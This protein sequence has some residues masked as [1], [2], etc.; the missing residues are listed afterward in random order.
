MIDRRQCRLSIVRQCALLGLAR[1]SYYYRKREQSADDE[2][3]MRLIDEQ[4]T[5]T[6]FYGIRK[7]TKALRRMGRVVNHKRVARLMRT[8]A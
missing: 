5:K 6:P 3:V 2:M 1:S 8:S 7:M 4:Y